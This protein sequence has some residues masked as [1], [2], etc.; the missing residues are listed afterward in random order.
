[1][2]LNKTN[3]LI[4]K[5]SKFKSYCAFYEDLILFCVF[6]DVKNGFYIDVGANDPIKGSVTNALYLK[7]WS[8]I[9]IEP[10]PKKYDLLVKKRPRD[11][12]LNIGVGNTKGYSL[13]YLAGYCST[14]NK[15]YLINKDNNKTISKEIFNNK[16]Y[17]I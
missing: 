9:N 16:D 15:T 10:L 13:L 12:N 8:G 6:S 1:M 11:I 7:G 2:I 3:S 17:Y 4:Q 5:I 14:L